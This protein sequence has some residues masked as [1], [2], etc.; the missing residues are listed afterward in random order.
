MQKTPSKKPLI[1]TI[2]IILLAVGGYFAYTGLPNDDAI[3]SVDSID[4]ASTND[5]SVASKRVLDLL[6]VIQSLNI[7]TEIFANPVFQSLIDHT[8]LVPSQNIGRPNP[9]SPIIGNTPAPGRATT[10]QK[11]TTTRR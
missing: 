1:I 4:L 5:A 3:S 7:D 2:V 11:K 6:A 9:F 8:V 10:T